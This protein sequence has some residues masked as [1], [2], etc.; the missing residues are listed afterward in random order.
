[1]ATLIPAKPFQSFSRPVRLFAALLIATLALGQWRSSAKDPA[2]ETRQSQ[3]LAHGVPV[4]HAL[5]AGQSQTW[6][7]SLSEGDY[8][9]LSVESKPATVAAELFA[10]GQSRQSGDK[11]LLSVADGNVLTLHQT[12]VFSII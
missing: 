10:P 9:R 3:T 2:Q 12:S 1:M 8:L 4:E 7:I 5:A 6:Q 11:P